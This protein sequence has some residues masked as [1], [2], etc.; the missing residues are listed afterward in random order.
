MAATNRDLKEDIKVGRFRQD[1]YFRLNVF[2][3]EVV[4]L[5]SR[6]EDIPVLATHLVNEYGKKMGCSNVQLTQANILKLQRY[7]WPRN[8]SELQNVIERA[9]ITAQCGKLCF[10]LSSPMNMLLPE[11]HDT[12]S[13]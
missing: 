9:I 12:S 2:P 3:I 5:R 10:N 6:K 8:I 11:P 13:V 4:S 1:L 7:D